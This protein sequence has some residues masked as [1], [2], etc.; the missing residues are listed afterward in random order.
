MLSLSGSLDLDEF[1]MDSLDLDN[2]EDINKIIHHYERY[3]TADN[4]TKPPNWQKLSSA[5]DE[6]WGAMQKNCDKLIEEM[7]KKEEDNNK[8]IEID[9]LP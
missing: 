8:E 7:I 5:A 6:S 1:E 3:L 2:N 9:E 4:T